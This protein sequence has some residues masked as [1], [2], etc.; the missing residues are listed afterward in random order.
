MI[1]NF[2]IYTDGACS[3]N[4]GPGGWAYIVVKDNN[5]VFQ[6]TGYEKETTNNRMEMMAII[7]ALED[8]I[9][10]KKVGPECVIHVYTDSAYILNCYVNH[11]WDVWLNNN[12]QTA[13]KKSVKNKE[14]W[15]RLIPLFQN[16]YIWFHKVE[17][18]SGNKWNEMVDV[19][20][21]QARQKLC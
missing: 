8:L 20:A 13:S 9:K 4:P 15:E 3:G 21:V 19:L 10:Q 6:C 14:L 17:G 16:K 2:E 11:W 18:H 5:V 7:E 12:W 1:M